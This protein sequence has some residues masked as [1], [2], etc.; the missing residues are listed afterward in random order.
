MKFL[1]ITEDLT[2]ISSLT[3]FWGNLYVK[4]AEL[5]LKANL[6][7][8]FFMLGLKEATLVTSLSSTKLPFKSK[9]IWDELLSKNKLSLERD[10]AWKIVNKN[11]A[12]FFSGLDYKQVP[13]F[14]TWKTY[15]AIHLSHGV[16]VY[17][18][19]LSRIL[20]DNLDGLV[21][22][23]SG[24]Q[25]QL[26]SHLSRSMNIK[27]IHWPDFGIAKI[28]RW[29]LDWLYSR[30]LNRRAFRFMAVPLKIKTK[31]KKRGIILAASFFRHL[32][33]LLPLYLKLQSNKLNSLIVGDSFE[34]KKITTNA[35]VID[36]AYVDLAELV[37]ITNK[38]QLYFRQKQ[39]AVAHWRLIKKQIE[40]KAQTINRLLPRFLAGYL[41]TMCVEA[42]PL[43][44]LYLESAENLIKL[45]QARGIVLVSDVRPLEL[46]LGLMA[47]RLKTKS[48]LVSPNT[49]LSL[50]AVNQYLLAPRIAVIGPHIKKALIKQGIS[51]KKILEVGDLRYD[52]LSS[53]KLNKLKQKTLEGMGLSREDK[54]FLLISF[55]QNPRIP[56]NEKKRFFQLCYQAVKIISG[57]K[58][59]I[60]PHPTE[61]IETLKQ[62]V[63]K[64]GLTNSLITN[65]QEFELIDLL[66]ISQATLLTWSMSGFESL[67][68]GVPV[69]VVN[70]TG[71]NY[72]DIIPYVK[73]QG[74]QLAVSSEQLNSILNKLSDNAYKQQWVNQGKQFVSSYIKIPDGLAAERIVKLLA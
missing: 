62:Q 33:T 30:Q 15:L 14:E 70:P 56:L 72:D 43:M 42:F 58:L 66:S 64:W 4:T 7:C 29:L 35:G 45:T 63:G 18:Q 71:K 26:A 2:A 48:L 22:V 53:A 51:E 61:R 8:V 38:K 27:V 67:L 11:L 52:R 3:G 16:L 13:F 74:A 46:S 36:D 60:K 41:Q 1:V 37:S 21:L 55:R 34:V 73:D 12:V 68:A 50:D 57:A 23:G 69:V 65:N 49:I 40:T 32:K 31:F 24:Y 44:C 54:V 39:K 17:K 10:L 5:F 28:N 47:R 20:T 9:L 6:W 59:V 25:T 19:T